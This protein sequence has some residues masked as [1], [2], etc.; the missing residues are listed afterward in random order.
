MQSATMLVEMKG[1]AVCCTGFLL[2]R[3]SL[4]LPP[5]NDRT[6]SISYG[7]N[8]FGFASTTKENQWP[9]E[10]LYEIIR[11]HMSGERLR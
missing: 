2:S 8:P 7:G 11:K 4:T 9:D 10:A 1:V 5:R 3:L 6:G